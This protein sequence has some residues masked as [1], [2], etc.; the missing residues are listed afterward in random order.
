MQDSADRGDSPNPS[1]GRAEAD[2]VRRSHRRAMILLLL[3]L[4]TSCGCYVIMIPMPG[5]SYSGPLPPVT[6]EETQ[7]AEAL[8]R[9]VEKLAQEIGE[10]N[11]WR[12]KEY[13]EAAV[14]I[15]ESLKAA[16]CRVTR[17]GF[18][19]NGHTCFN[20]EGEIKGSELPD[21][22]LI[23]GA[24]YD[25]VV[26]V[27]GANDN[28]SGIAGV[29]ALA[30]AFGGKRPRRTLRFVAFA[31]EEP[32]FFQTAHMGSRVYAKACRERGDNVV[33]MISLETIGYYSDSKGSQKYPFPL[34]L[35]Y[36][37]TGNFIAF[38]GNVK[39]RKLVRRVVGSFRK[40]TEFPSEGAAVPGFVPGI[41]W[42]DHEGFWR[43]GYPALMVT[44]TAL[45][46]YPYY[47]SPLDTPDKLDYERLA[48]VV[49]GIERV[50]IELA[51]AE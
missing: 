29:L 5:K 4:L 42:S 32:P 8:R 21:E 37:S 31:N 1:G 38:V 48:R 30:R 17:Q 39:S 36:P 41:D 3:T 25:S 16:G 50:V 15:E 2:A 22:S 27:P 19:V 33:A 26:G 13:E 12:K 46:R 51:E 43:V 45:Y 18:D 14:F 23:V 44:D 28:A 7:L 6:A 20:I 11:W 9:D 10:R 47:H 40:H 35:L 24:H 34:N 49:A